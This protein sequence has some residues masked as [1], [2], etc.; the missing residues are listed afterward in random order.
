[1]PALPPLSN[2]QTTSDN[3]VRVP[4]GSVKSLTVGSLGYG[5]GQTTFSHML[6]DLRGLEGLQMLNL[7]KHTEPG[8]APF[9]L[10]QGLPPSLKG[11]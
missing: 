11:G 9:E 7:S 4:P 5:L 8:G 2:L 6:W 10:P 3:P 1:M